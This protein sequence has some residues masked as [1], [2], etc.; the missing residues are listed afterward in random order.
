MNQRRLTRYERSLPDFSCQRRRDCTDDLLRDHTFYVCT[1][2]LYRDY[3]SNCMRG[4]V[5]TIQEV[6]HLPIEQ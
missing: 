2:T 3:S 1:G 4:F 5:G 6:G